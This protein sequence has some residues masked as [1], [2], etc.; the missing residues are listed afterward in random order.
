[1]LDTAFYGVLM[2]LGVVA[3]WA[4]QRNISTIR[5]VYGSTK[6]DITNLTDTDDTVLVSGTVGTLNGNVLEDPLTGDSSVVYDYT[7]ERDGDNDQPLK[8]VEED[9]ERVPFSIG[10]NTGNAV[11][12]PENARMVL[13]RETQIEIES[14]TPLATRLNPAEIGNE[15]YTFY[16]SGESLNVGDDVYVFAT[17]QIKN[18]EPRLSDNAGSEFVISENNP[19]ETFQQL[20]VQSAV[21]GIIGIGFVLGFG[22]MLVTTL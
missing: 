5:T 4:S 13:E 22:Y 20:A 18:G 12:N 14:G 19:K 17:P 7:V 2:A 21:F 11:V 1:M 3:L 6:T 9:E 15:L 8:T 10:D 16:V